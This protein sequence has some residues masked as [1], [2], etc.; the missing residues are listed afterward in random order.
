MRVC[1][2]P[3]DFD[4]PG[5]YRC[6]FPARELRARGH[7]AALPPWDELPMSEGSIVRFR[8]GEVP[9]SDVYVLHFPK[10]SWHPKFARVMRAQGGRVVVDVDD[11]FLGVPAYNI[12]SLGDYSNVFETMRAA[13]LV[14]VSTPFLAEA[15]SRFNPKVRVLRNRLDWE[16]WAD[17]PQQ[18]EVERRRVRVG[19]MGQRRYSAGNLNVLKGVIGPFLERHPEVEFVAAGDNLVHADLGVPDGRRYPD[20]RVTTTSVGFRH[21]DL[22]DITACMDIGLVPL[23]RN[24][25]NEG[26]S[27]LKGMEY[28]ACGIPCVATPTESYRHW[29]E[30]GV[31]GLLAKRGNDWLRHLE[32]L[33]SD[34]DLRREMGRNAR[35]RAEAS[36]IQEHVGEWE[37]TYASLL[38]DRRDAQP[39]GAARAAG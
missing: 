9:V 29:V 18:S 33:V 35:A 38:G 30:P 7:E 14:T 37:D 32:L 36:T 2:F 26:K 8:L 13:D 22:A 17:A 10:G 31:N 27:H 5:C 4:G 21:F 28:A 39:A 16:M 23:E 1:V 3:A 24:N 12:G 15:Y 6:V 20:R 19:W 25:F 11:Y 34:D